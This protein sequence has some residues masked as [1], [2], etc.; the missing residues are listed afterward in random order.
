MCR[1]MPSL[2][3]QMSMSATVHPQFGEEAADVPVGVRAERGLVALGERASQKPA[4][5]VEVYRRVE[6]DGQIAGVG[7]AGERGEHA[8]VQRR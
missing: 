6:L 1:P 3:P 8:N 2:A 5:S 4:L 7:A